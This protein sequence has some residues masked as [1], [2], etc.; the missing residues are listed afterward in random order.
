MSSRWSASTSLGISGDTNLAQEVVAEKPN[1]FLRN[2]V[3]S[4]LNL[5]NLLSSRNMTIVS[6]L[7][8]ISILKLT[9]TLTLLKV[10]FFIDPDFL[11]EVYAAQHLV[12][13]YIFYT[14]NLFK[15]WS[16]SKLKTLS[17]GSSEYRGYLTGHTLY[18]TPA[19]FPERAVLVESPSLSTAKKDQSLLSTPALYNSLS[20]ASYYLS[21]LDLLASNF[22]VLSQ[23]EKVGLL[24]LTSGVTVPCG[25]VAT[26]DLFLKAVN[27]SNKP[28]FLSEQQ[29][30]LPLTSLGQH[31]HAVKSVGWL[32]FWDPTLTSKLVKQA[33]DSTQEGR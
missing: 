26:S 20:N 5:I 25:R 11:Y 33:T 3:L 27:L 7:V 17:N 9:L 32:E 23:R 28:L 4:P 30:Q 10:L 13:L 22:T 19:V 12:Y 16:Q 8:Y 18:V 21:S 31:T 1:S 6:A 29:A 2:V 24:G 14:L 15:I